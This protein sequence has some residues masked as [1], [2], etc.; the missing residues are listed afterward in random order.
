VLRGAGDK[1]PPNH[2]VTPQSS[3]APRHHEVCGTSRATAASRPCQ[4]Q[5]VEHVGA[6]A[7]HFGIPVFY[8]LVPN[9]S[10]GPENKVIPR[11]NLQNVQQWFML[12][13]RMATLALPRAAA[14]KL[15]MVKGMR[16]ANGGSR[17]SHTVFSVHTQGATMFTSCSGVERGN[18][19]NLAR[20]PH[21]TRP[22]IFVALVALTTL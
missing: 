18:M 22:A 17:G 11:V 9:P 7:A 15:S 3:L 10:N 2:T 13:H 5:R 19:L 6:R 8:L 16:K 20:Y 1:L 14:G 21:H 4:R 12:H